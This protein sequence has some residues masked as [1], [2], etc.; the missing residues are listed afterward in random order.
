MAGALT[1]D[2]IT[3]A[4]ADAA[5][6]GAL[7]AVD[8]AEPGDTA[9]VPGDTALVPGP[10]LVAA[11]AMLESAFKACCSALS[12]RSSPS[13]LAWSNAVAD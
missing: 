2:L 5:P 1:A 8:P 4:A 13:T 12:W 7:T 6:T 11:P 3:G 10:A 9:L